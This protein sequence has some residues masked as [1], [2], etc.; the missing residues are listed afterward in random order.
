[1]RRPGLLPALIGAALLLTLL[2]TL[3]SADS[4]VFVKGG[5]VWMSEPDGSRETRLTRDGTFRYASQSED[6]SIAASRGS[7]VVRLSRTGEILASHPT[8]V[9]ENA[10]YG[11]YDTEISPDGRLIAYEYFHYSDFWGLRLG[12][13]YLDARTGE[14]IGDTHT[15]WSYP[16]WVDNRRLIHSGGPTRLHTDVM[17]REAGEPNNLG[18]EWFSH[19]DANGI[20]D[21]DISR[22]GSVLAFVGGEHDE[23][24]L[25]YRLAGQAGVVAPEY[26]Y[27]YLEP[28]GRYRD[29]AISP[30]G[31]RLA[32]QEGDGIHVGPL[33][34]LSA[35]CSMPA[36]EG[37]LVIPG[38]TNPD[39]G[40]ASP[41]VPR[42]SIRLAGT[43]R[44]GPALRQGLRLLVTGIRSG[45][46][47]RASVSRSTSR[48]LGLGASPRVVAGGRLSAGP[49]VTLRFQRTLRS[50]LRRARVLPLFITGGEVRTRLT[51]RR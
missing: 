31:R 7:K 41:I 17:L 48:R 25:V 49:R 33:P 19:P 18:I 23:L 34:D 40:P 43:Q 44:I 10:S 32:W 6:G 12:V 3:A 20:R 45:T 30:D 5:D 16:S 27:H 24:L 47:I 1:M 4:L 51:L 13:A 15:G 2:P 14:H 38:G 39:W 28:Q 50:K 29:P 8:A 21:G 46:S 9:G 36:E 11:P 22:D 37:R 26:C 35:G 42:R